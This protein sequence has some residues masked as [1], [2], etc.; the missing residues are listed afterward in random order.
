[1]KSKLLII[2]KICYRPFELNLRLCLHGFLEGVNFVPKKNRGG[3]QS[4]K[5]NKTISLLPY[6]NLV[7][8]GAEL[9]AGSEKLKVKSEK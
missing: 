1:M 4:Y 5:A 9:Y 7:N 3:G 2:C 8:E 6:Y